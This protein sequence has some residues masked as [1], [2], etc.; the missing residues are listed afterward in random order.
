MTLL[1]WDSSAAFKLVVDESGSERV[2]EVYA[3]CDRNITLDWTSLELASALWKQAI[4]GP[5]DAAAAELAMETFD[6]LDFTIV[7]AE[8]LCEMA[9]SFAL[10]LR[11]PVYD[12]M[13]VALA[14]QE[15]ATLVTADSR[16]RAIAETAGVNV[17]WIAAD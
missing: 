3:A 11:H 16:L 9:L 15:H 1:A 12:C 13:Y 17:L 5:M 2:R 4:R 10:R 14:L 6:R 7:H 8:D